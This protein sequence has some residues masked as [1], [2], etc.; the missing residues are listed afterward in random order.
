MVCEY[1][2]GF[3]RD[4]ECLDCGER[5]CPHGDPLHYHHDGCPSCYDDNPEKETKRV[6]E[7]LKGVEVELPRR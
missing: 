2:S 5:D 4:F 6:F 1:C 7:R 3:P